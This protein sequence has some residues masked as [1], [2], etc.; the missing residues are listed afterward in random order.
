MRFQT[1]VSIYSG[2][3]TQTSPTVPSDE[4]TLGFEFRNTGSCDVYINNMRLAPEQT[5]RTFE[6]GA[7]DVTTYRI[8]FDKFNS[9]AGINSEL[10]VITFSLK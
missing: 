3:T 7:V 5:F 4:R 2:L 6:A 9:C 10:T 8:R 1:E